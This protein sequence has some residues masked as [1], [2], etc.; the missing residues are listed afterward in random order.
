MGGGGS[1]DRLGL[2]WLQW[3]CRQYF[4][5]HYK[6]LLSVRLAFALPRNKTEHFLTAYF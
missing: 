5:S 3:L 2:G 1:T 6:A 4:P